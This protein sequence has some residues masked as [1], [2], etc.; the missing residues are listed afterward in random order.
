M[1]LFRP[2]LSPP[3]AA[4]A[5][6]GNPEQPAMPVTSSRLRTG[7]HHLGIVMR[8]LHITRCA[9]HQSPPAVLSSVAFLR[10]RG[11]AGGL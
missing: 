8:C 7:V 1:Q 4:L 3:L 2:L 5:V 6:C 11:T 10:I 9:S